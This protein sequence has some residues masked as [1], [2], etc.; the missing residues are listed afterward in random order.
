MS[1]ESI[2][3]MNIRKNRQLTIQTM[4]SNKMKSALK[5]NSVAKEPMKS[6]QQIAKPYSKTL[7]F[8]LFIT[9]GY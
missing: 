5:L 3:N 2:F 8:V 1:T 9:S 6:T 7:N 4:V